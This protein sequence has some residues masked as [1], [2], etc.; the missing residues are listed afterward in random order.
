[1]K[2][3]PTPMRGMQPNNATA[4]SA[5]VDVASCISLDLLKLKGSLFM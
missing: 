3:T 2:A 1:M 5:S 4:R